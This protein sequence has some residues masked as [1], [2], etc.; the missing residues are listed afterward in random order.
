LDQSNTDELMAE[1]P[2]VELVATLERLGL[3]TA[4]QVTQMA[5]RVGR[6]AKDLPR[7]DSVWIDALAQARV[8][9]PFQAGELNAGRG[10]ML[11]LGPYLLCQRLAHP[12]YVASYRAR[13]IDS[14]ETVRLAVIEN[15]GTRADA[16]QRKLKSLID[17]ERPRAE[18]ENPPSPSLPLSPSPSFV[19]HV[20]IDGNRIFAVSPWIDGQTAAEWMV[21]HGRFPPEVVLE[22]ARAMLAALVE[23]EKIGACHSDV[24][25]S[26]LMLSDA[27][28]VMLVMPGLRGI[29][30]PEEGYAYTD[31]PPEAFDGL[32]PE[33]IASGTP[34]N[35]ASDV[36]AC[37][38]VWW[39]LLCGRPAL[40]GGDSLT[41]L[42]AA[43]A[44]G[45]CD[46]RR[47][48]PDV[49][50]PLAAAISACVAVE[51]SRRP[52]SM[53]RLAAMLG[54]PT[55]SGKAALADCLTRTGRPTV[56]WTTTTRAIRRSSRTPLWLAGGVCCLAAVVAILWPGWHSKG[57]DGLLT[58][59]FSDKV[60]SEATTQCEAA[61]GL[62]PSSLISHP[63]PSTP[64]SPIISGNDKNAV[65]P[66]SFQQ[67]LR[68]PPD[69]VLAANKPL[70]EGR[71]ELRAGQ[72]VRSEPGRRTTLLVPET[73]FVVDMENVR[74]EN[75]D[76]VW[77]HASTNRIK[78]DRLGIVRLLAGR[79]EFRG[80]S[81][82]CQ[83]EGDGAGRKQP[84]TTIGTVPL[85]PVPA[86]RWLYPAEAES[87]ETSLPSGQIRLVDCLFVKVG[88][89]L[90]CQ[91]IGALGIEA[92][93][94]LHLGTGPLLALDHFPRADEP[95]S[96][97]LSQVTLRGG[98]PLLECLASRA[99]QQPA[100]IAVSSAA[101]VFAPRSGEPLVRFCGTTTPERLPHCLRWIGQGSLVTPN[102]PILTCQ[103]PDEQPQTVDESSLSIAG[104][105][106]GEVG[107]AGKLSSDPA[108]SQAIRWE[109]P[110]RSA[111]PPGVDPAPL[112]CPGR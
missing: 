22:I 19:R 34:P 82:R 31:L 75:I 89:G 66:A 63:L 108:A 25:T 18:G 13:N 36:Y 52:E 84:D 92:T 71:F 21:H 37:G 88:A 47:Y 90:E 80:C 69:L 105:V 38:C 50:P 86:I 16:I 35:S 28:N 27:G 102:T 111:D 9:T 43:Q 41:K 76:F 103:G 17:G 3:A 106:R 48:A 30:R 55:S 24:S 109:A 15:A 39:H 10:S 4:E 26:S 12:L 49:P 40:A 78:N 74:F 45:I 110:L 46:V 51:P 101:C 93:N 14:G 95:V 81:F 64:D 57:L 60:T 100:E 68:P 23:L 67:P 7:F 54:L 77:N 11:R 32:A 94:T 112:A 73:G 99:D 83:A 2:P 65:V 1:L 61:S 104:L 87:S 6:L 91:T 42:R 97:N 62:H 29:L 58:S 79:A 5:R 70:T 107:F 56:H 72:C 20:G 59:E 96:L 53:A 98:G 85:V 33:R 8:L 44:G